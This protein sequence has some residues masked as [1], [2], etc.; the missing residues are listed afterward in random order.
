MITALLRS[1][2]RRAAVLRRGLLHRLTPMALV[3]ATALT[4]T[5]GGLSAPAL[6][7]SEFGQQEL[8]QS[9]TIAVAK[10]VDNGRFYQL[11]ILRQVSNQRACWQELP[12][13]PTRIDPLLLNFDF[14]GI[15][16]RSVDSNGYSVRLAGEDLNWQYRLQLVKQGG[17]LVLQAVSAANRAAPPLT[18]G[19]TNGLGEGFLKVSLDPG[20]RLTQ[21]LYN[22]Q[23]LGHVYVTHDQSLAALAGVPSAPVPPPV[24]TPPIVATPPRQPVP[25]P[26][27]LPPVVVPSP[28]T[29]PGPPSGNPGA[30]TNYRVIVPNTSADTQRRV[31]AVEPGAFRTTLNGQSVIQAG[32]FQEQWRAIELQQNLMAARI[33]AQ[34][35][36]G[37]GVVPPRPNPPLP[38][39]QSPNPL[40]PTQ[41][42]V[43]RIRVILDP[44]H[45]GRDPGA[46]GI[47]GLQEKEINLDIARRVQ[48]ILESR[49]IAV[50]LTRP[51]DVEVELEP[52]VDQAE[53]MAAQLFVSIHANAISM[54]R[55]EVNGLETYYYDSGS[56]LAQTIHNSILRGTDLRDRG[57]R[58]AR[59][60][61][62]RNTSMPSVLVET[63]FVT[64]SEDAARFR[65]SEA[66][67]QI[68][69][70]IAQGILTYAQQTALAP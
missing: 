27:P 47:G 6:A 62:L 40:P 49:G 14:T 18:I 1:S 11:L 58:Q 41:I 34:I 20:W 67:G 24:T 5:L 26:N 70:A 3:T 8:D 22:G 54:D 69:Q 10:P 2:I 65:N 60:Y 30:A 68:A 55:P 53:R 31:Q 44:G 28:P 35:I 4:A 57:V 61:V 51:G 16:D 59:F 13:Q 33:P 45:G 56:G 37:T 32:L 43:G 36:Q 23:P 64:G 21:R 29:L 9:R 50:M 7:L 52:R 42:P 46:V 63:G 19:R 15:C 12:G 25:Q 17:Q 66:R 39:P 38:N 48:Q